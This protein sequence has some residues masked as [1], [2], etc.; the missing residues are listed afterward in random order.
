MYLK[1]VY[2]YNDPNF[3]FHFYLE[4]LASTSCTICISLDFKNVICILMYGHEEIKMFNATIIVG[5]KEKDK[6]IQS[7]SLFVRCTFPDKRYREFTI[8]E[9]FLSHLFSILFSGT[10]SLLFSCKESVGSFHCVYVILI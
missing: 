9:N 7:F 4:N 1:L 2:I 8:I 3:L 6:C 5:V 10:A